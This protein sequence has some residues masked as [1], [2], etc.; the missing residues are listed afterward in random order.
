MP[1]GRIISARVLPPQR[2][3]DFI[4]AGVD[5][6]FHPSVFRLW[7]NPPPLIGGG[8]FICRGGYYPP[9]FNETGLCPSSVFF[10]FTEKSNYTLAVPKIFFG[11]RL[12]YFDRGA[13]PCSLHRPQDALHR[14]C[15]RGRLF[16]NGSVRW[17]LPKIK[18]GRIS[19]ALFFRIISRLRC[20]P[21]ED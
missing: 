2:R 4:T 6:S 16:R 21:P 20:N 17:I 13:K 18:K 12:E 7:R 1:Q 11:I 5:V 15:S 3:R 19:S 8:F 9:V 14:L 10:G